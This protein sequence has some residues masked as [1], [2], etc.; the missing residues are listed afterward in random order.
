MIPQACSGALS[1]SS[2][3]SSRVALT[4]QSRDLL[5]VTQQ[6]NGR[7]QGADTG[8]CAVLCHGNSQ[9]FKAKYSRGERFQSWAAL[10]LEATL[11]ALV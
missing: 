2:L 11:G 9:G 6:A 5:K 7:S 1:S 4:T 3:K 8:P 10:Q